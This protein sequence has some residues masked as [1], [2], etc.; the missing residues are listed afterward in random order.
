MSKLETRMWFFYRATRY[1]DI[2][3]E[4]LHFGQCHLMDGADKDHKNWWGLRQNRGFHT[5]R[6]SQ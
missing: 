5:A 6:C 4:A 1:I 2:G 3:F